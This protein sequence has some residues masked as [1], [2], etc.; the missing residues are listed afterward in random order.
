MRA[1]SADLPADSGTLQM[2]LMKHET[3]HTEKVNS[4]LLN[5]LHYHSLVFLEL[6]YFHNW[7]VFCGCYRLGKKQ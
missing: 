5:Q 4:C 2:A 7:T 3:L 1:W 6:A